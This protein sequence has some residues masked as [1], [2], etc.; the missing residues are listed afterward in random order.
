MVYSSVRPQNIGATEIKS[1][2]NASITRARSVYAINFHL[3]DR[4]IKCFSLRIQH[5]FPHDIISTQHWFT[6]Q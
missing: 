3:D 5:A 4:A 1:R 2:T 6:S